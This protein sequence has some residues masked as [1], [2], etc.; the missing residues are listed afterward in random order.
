MLYAIIKN[1]TKNLPKEAS[2]LNTIQKKSSLPC[3]P[4]TKYLSQLIVTFRIE[5]SVPNFIVEKLDK[6]N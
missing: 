4:V 6:A 1:A 5:H 3:P 2:V